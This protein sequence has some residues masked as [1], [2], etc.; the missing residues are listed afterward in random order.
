[1]ARAGMTDLIAQ[2]RRMTDAIGDTST[3]PD[4]TLQSELDK[5]RQTFKALP[6]KPLAELS[7]GEYVY[8]EYPFPADVRWVEHNETGSGWAV[9]DGDGN[10]APSYSVNYDARV[11]TFDADT[12]D[13]TYYLSCR[14]YDL[15]AV[16]SEIWRQKAAA[17]A[18]NVDWQSDNHRVSN[19]QQ[20]RHALEMAAYYER[21]RGATSA[22]IVRLDLYAD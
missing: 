13:T 10:A 12:S 9:L 8:L 18:T 22:R 15:Y 19:S 11:I 2:L 14:A 20:H 3:W 21:K 4:D 17:Y 7:S 6:I 16:A 1:M 5:R